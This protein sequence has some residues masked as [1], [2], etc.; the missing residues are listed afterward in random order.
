MIDNKK[1]LKDVSS[2]YSTAQR[3]KKYV[4]AELDK[5]DE[6]YR[7]IIAEEK[8]RL[9]EQ[10]EVLNAQIKF[11]AGI[12]NPEEIPAP[13]ESESKAEQTPA[14]EEEPVITD[15][16]FPE[17]NESEEVVESDPV[18]EDAG[19]PAGVP[20]AGI[21]SSDA[22]AADKPAESS[23]EEKKELEDED[24][25][26]DLNG[27]IKKE[28]S[29]KEKSDLDAEEDANWTERIESGELKEVAF[30]ESNTETEGDPS[31]W[32]EYQEKQKPAVQETADDWSDVQWN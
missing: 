4:V 5:I 26:K 21:P 30:E 28:K 20:D 22:V 9:N 13:E 1:Y 18:A 14:V 16:I 6:K 25:A 7:K 15:T 12:V 23:E 11:Y 24:M 32:P 29:D 17:N 2:L 8:K 3:V 31:Q 10:L 19:E 27:V